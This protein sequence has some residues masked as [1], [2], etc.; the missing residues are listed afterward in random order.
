MSGAQDGKLTVQNLQVLFVRM[1][2]TERIEAEKRMAAFE[3]RLNSQAR[4][5]GKNDQ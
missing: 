2:E 5:E 1:N 4:P 3:E